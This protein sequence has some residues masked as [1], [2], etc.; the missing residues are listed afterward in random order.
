LSIKEAYRVFCSESDSIPL[1]SQPCWLDLLA[2]DSGLDWDVV[3][4]KES[5]EFRAFLPFCFSK[6]YKVFDQ[7]TMPKLTPYLSPVFC[8][9]QRLQLPNEL[10]N[11]LN[12]CL[13]LIQELPNCDTLIH[14]FSPEIGLLDQLS[15]G[16]LSLDFF[17]TYVISN[18]SHEEVKK[19]FRSSLIRQIKKGEKTLLIL[20]GTPKELFDL[21]VKTFGRQGKE[22]PYSLGII[23]AI[24]EEVTSLNCGEILVTK[25]EA[26]NIHSGG[27]FVSDSQNY[28]YL[29][30]AGDPEFRNSGAQSYLLNYT[31]A[32]AMKSGLSFDFEG[33]MVPSIAKF[34]SNF[35]GE[36][37]P[38]AGLFKKEKSSF[39]IAKKIDKLFHN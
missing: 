31:I 36:L 39:R 32:K 37:K 35:G 13:G 6:R 23:T 1:F 26:G 19:G 3:G 5:D 17:I 15:K 4:V 10:S 38:Y 24:L 29:I 27:L 11:N 34:F 14:R 25:D 7:I 8:E 28:Y 16:R 33:S 2:K 30:G 9:T 21:S 20:S 12:L 22:C 18:K